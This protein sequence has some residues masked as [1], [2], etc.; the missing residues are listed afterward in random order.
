VQG[1]LASIAFADA[2][3]GRLLNALDE[4]DYAN[5]TI[6][7]LW[8][9]HGWHL[10]EKLHWRKFSLWEEADRA[11]L[12][13]I[14]PGV[15]KPGQ[16]CERTVSFMDVYPTL[17]DLCG[18]PIGKYLEGVSLRPLLE[19][20]SATWDLSTITTH[21]IN[22]HAV[23]SERWRYIRYADGTEELYDHDVDPLEWKNLAKDQKY[24]DVKK[25]LTKWLPKKNAPNAEF[26]KSKR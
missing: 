19:D 16:K 23:R 7:V 1:Y 2:Q 20:T 21:G 8:G 17:A 6:V 24:N 25:Q 18:L 5:N 22:N 10:G 14:A 9:D 3:V 13:I 15:T 26:D 4:S 12:M 11:P